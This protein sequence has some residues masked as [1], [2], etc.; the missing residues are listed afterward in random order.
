MGGKVK[1]STIENL[2]V[3][4]NLLIELNNRGLTGVPSIDQPWK[5]FYSQDD[6]SIV[7]PEMTLTEY[8]EYKNANRM[9]LN[10]IRYLEKRITY[11][12]LL[13]NIY[14][15]AKR[16]KNNGVKEDDYVSLAMPLTPETIYMIYGLDL[17]GANA[18][19]IDPRVPAER[20]RFYLNLANSRMAAVISKY[21]DT[22]IQA[23]EKTGVKQ[24]IDVSPIEYFTSEEKKALALKQY[25]KEE[26]VSIKVKQLFQEMQDNFNNAMSLVTGRAKI[27]QYKQFSKDDC[28]D[29]SRV[30]YKK[31]RTAITEY[32]SGTTGVPKGLQLTASGM[33]VTV[34]QLIKTIGAQPGESILAIMPPFISYGAVCGIHNSLG[35]GLEMI[36]IPNFTVENFA[37]LI[38]KYNPNNIIC[39]PSFFRHV[40]SN[41]IF[42]EKDL[43]NIYRVIFG[44][45]KT[46]PNLEKDVN[47]WLEKHNSKAKVIKG[48]GMAEY[49]SCAFLTPY[50][51]TKKPGVYG[52]PLPLVEAKIMK[53]DKEECG[54][55]EIGEIYIHSPQQMKGYLNND[56]ETNDFFYTDENGKKWGRTGDL[57][58]V[59]IDG[60]FS[61][62][63]RKKNMIVRPDGHNVFPNEI[64]EAIL[65]TNLVQNCV[66]IGIKE[67]EESSGE[68]PYAFIELKKECSD[69]PTESLNKI[70]KRVE[71]QIPLRDRPRDDDY[72]LTKMAYK[73]EGKLDREAMVCMVKK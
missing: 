24:I 55:Y 2:T 51:E 6:L 71:S 9:S 69:K 14:S 53:N 3:N 47:E 62:T 49:S 50:P 11:E 1:M 32:T 41:P 63:T 65:K 72:I 43:S 16:F 66:V 46:P 25:S 19:L 22:M 56:T 29:L 39:V 40:I 31:D 8:I 60:I 33:N 44:G 23:S 27:K 42:N 52:I 7:I 68:Y 48:G 45:D 34:E 57:G 28:F 36:L 20:M 35:S 70:K 59:D 38:Y 61:L 21:R 17:I 30:P 26:L 58:F 4:D 67:D 64:E 73:S 12:Q 54:Y 13:E 15:T 37:E 5:Q 18:N 10:A